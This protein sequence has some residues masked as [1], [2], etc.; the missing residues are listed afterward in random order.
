MKKIVLVLLLVT[1]GL[2]SA[3]TAND[4][5]NAIVVCGNST[6]SSNASGFGT[7]ELDNESNPCAFEEVNSLWLRLNVDTTGMLSFT[8]TPDNTDISV[9]YDFYVFGPNFNCGSFNDPIRCSTTNPSQAGLTNNL[10]G[11]RDSENDD[12]EGPGSLGNSFV[13]SL[14]V[15]AGETYYLLIDRPL[16]NGGFS[17]DWNG[18]AN[19]IDPPPIIG[20]PD[21]FELC[22]ADRGS[23]LDLTQN[24]NQIATDPMISFEYFLS[25]ADAF[26]GSNPLA[27]PTNYLIQ[28]ATTVY[29]KV[30]GANSCF[31]VLDQQIIIDEPV[32]ATLEYIACDPNGDGIEEFQI[33]QIVADVQSEIRNP[34]NYTVSIH[35]TQLEADN[36]T[37]SIAAAGYTTATTQL[38]AR[39]EANSNN[40]CFSTLAIGLE[41]IPSPIVVPTELVQCDIDLANSTDGITRVNLDE[42]F[43][44]VGT[45][46]SFQ[47][48]FFESE[49]E[50]SNDEAIPNPFDYENS[51]PFSQLL[52]YRIRTDICTILGEM[53]LQILPTP[54]VLNVQS[55]LVACDQ[56]AED[57][58]LSGAFDLETFGNTVYPGTEVAF[59]ATVEDAS[60]ELNPLPAVFVS[61]AR[62]I[63]IRIEDGN[64]CRTVEE[65]SLLVNPL[66][67]VTLDPSYYICTENPEL[68]LTAP[69][70]FDRYR[71]IR[72]EG[73]NEIEVSN[74][75]PVTI[76][77]P[78][79]YRLEVGIAYVTNG[80][81]LLCYNSADFTVLPS[82][83]ATIVDIM[84]TDASDNNAIDI[85]VS[86]DG[87]YE[88]SL[89]AINYQDGSLFQNLP[90]GP[91]AVYIRDKNG[92]GIT[93]ADITILGYPKFFTPNGDNQND[94]WQL[95]GLDPALVQNTVISIFDRYGKLIKQFSANSGGWDGTSNS[96]LMPSADYWFKVK[97]G[98]SREFNGHFTLKR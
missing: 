26:D 48:D 58:A 41:V 46:T 29:V 32:V 42:F 91:A 24:Q 71:W 67:A 4:C 86:G 19:F 75:R 15:T 27:D 63:F 28:D 85:Q 72:T 38:Y 61:E 50:R 21:A 66:P 37:G 82:N 18:S 51:T 6:V 81:E 59:Y 87:D 30:T 8:L 20:Q 2:C 96:N 55:P 35:P 34:S 89:D 13:S 22:F 78:G 31:E 16:G 10:T 45:G 53:T 70:G 17:L 40:A 97:I 3:Q 64:Q 68:D 79:N 12:S 54:I 23:F 14:P 65:L 44:E 60:L 92:C 47:Y 83:A 62:S 77:G 88:Y 49:L 1:G 76:N 36:D 43:A 57:I 80:V 69:E 56:N 73:G 93:N 39:I 94:S 7:Q 33:S 25:R 5:T 74:A 52:Y 98:A 9:D 90:A 11:L 84:I 95:I